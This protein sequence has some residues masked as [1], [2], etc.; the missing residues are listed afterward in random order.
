MKKIVITNHASVIF[1]VTNKIEMVKKNHENSIFVVSELVVGSGERDEAAC[2][3]TTVFNKSKSK[4]KLKPL[5]KFLISS[6]FG[7][8]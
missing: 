2:F 8:Y 4:Q 3:I 6:K 5:L 1:F 7:L